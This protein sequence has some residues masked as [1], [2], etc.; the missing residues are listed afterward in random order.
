M[1]GLLG[2]RTARAGTGA[3]EGG[4]WGGPHPFFVLFLGP[5]QAPR[6]PTLGFA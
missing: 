6:P 5:L 2:N 3:S 4:A 1:E